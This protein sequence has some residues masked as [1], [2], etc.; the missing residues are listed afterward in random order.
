MKATKRQSRIARHRRVRARVFG[1]A[2]KPRMN[3]FRSTS[4]IYIQI[5]DDAQGKTLAAAS[6]KELKSKGKKSDL[7]T[8]AG[9][10]AAEKALALGI[11]EVVFDRGGYLYHGRIKACAE[12][13]RAAGLKF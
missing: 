2:A 7:A 5:I 4:H 1:T 13:A 12:G 3:V 10:K 11:K 6:T 9:K 8:E